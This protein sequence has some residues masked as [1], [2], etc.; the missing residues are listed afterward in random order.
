[1]EKVLITGGDGNLASE[2]KRTATKKNVIAPSKYEMDITN[3]QS[4]SSFLNKF[5]PNYLIHAAAFTRPMNKHQIFP[6]KS[7][8]VN[9]IGTSNIALNCLKRN[10]KLIYISTDY[11]YPGVK[12]NFSEDDSLSPY[13]EVNDGVSKYGWSKLG[14]ECA[15][16]IMENSLIIRACICEYPFPHPRALTDVKKSLIYIKDAAPI[17]WKLI[18]EI[19]VINLGGNPQSVYNFA[20]VDNKEVLP[21]KNSEILD[22]KL[23]PNT[24]MD[25]SKLKKIL[26]ETN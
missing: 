19:G 11:V 1:M 3:N 23:A 10:I 22:V 7:I 21:I 25:I 9:I 5:S 2:L 18:D 24:T 15:V 8:E 14:G 12:G 6:E 4:I 16:R 17:I 13:S 20:K 26:N